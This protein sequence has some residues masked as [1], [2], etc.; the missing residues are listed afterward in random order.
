M[1]SF[2]NIILS[3]K[4]L[5][6]IKLCEEKNNFSSLIKSIGFKICCKDIY[7][8][9]YGKYYID[10]YGSSYAISD[11]DLTFNFDFKYN[12]T[13]FLCE[14]FKKELRSIKIKKIINE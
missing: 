13:E 6:H 9:N 3:Q 5:D 11:D 8:Y 14:I 1:K 4:V 12:D 2:K 10:L 7:Y